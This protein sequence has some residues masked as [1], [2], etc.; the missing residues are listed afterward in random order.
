MSQNV[1]LIGA[2]KGIGYAAAKM[3]AER[4]HCVIG[5]SRREIDIAEFETV[6]LDVGDENT[7]RAGVQQA[8]A[9]MGHIDVLINNAGYDLYGAAEETS[10]DELA[11]QMD[12]NFFG[13]VRVI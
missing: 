6:A 8:L 5:S 1:L 7:I 11:S 3:L 10:F 13:S 2:S 12:T 9:K 4:G